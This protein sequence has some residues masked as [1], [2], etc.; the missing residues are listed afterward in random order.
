[1]VRSKIVE[2]WLT[3]ANRDL[4]FAKAALTLD[5]KFYDEIVFHCQQS[6]EKSI[7]GFLAKNK[8]PFSKTHD[9][10]ELLTSVAK[11]DLELTSLLSGAKIL[12]K[13]AVAIRYPDIEE[14]EVVIDGAL[15]THCI[16]LADSVYVEISARI[17]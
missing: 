10:G 4:R 2:Q 1:M 5:E 15:A 16:A 14:N 11:V 12:T 7:K 9:I 8:Q 6:V 17:D 13:Y 3:K